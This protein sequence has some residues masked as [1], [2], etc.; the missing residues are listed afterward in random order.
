VTGFKPT[1]G[2]I[3]LAGI[4][5]GEQ[6]PDDTIRWLSHAGSTTQTANDTSVVARA[7]G[8]DIRASAGRPRLGVPNNVRTDDEV[9]R[10]IEEAVR[11]IGGAGYNFTP[12]AAPLYD[13][14]EGIN[15]IETDRAA[16]T[17]RVFRDV[18]LI[19]L[20]TTPSATATVNVAS[21]NQLA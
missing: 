20:P 11:A 15:A 16:V 18:D 10:R 8:V 1:F 6:P 17:G 19:P 12:T 13:V 5:E 21:N 7:L 9:R 4:L 2:A 3:P 14:R